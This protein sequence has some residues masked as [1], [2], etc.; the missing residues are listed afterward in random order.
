MDNKKFHSLILVRPQMG[1]N[2]GACARAMKNFNFFNELR[3]VSPRDGWPNEKALRN[4]AGGSDIIESAKIFDNLNDAISDLEYLY[5]STARKRDMNINSVEVRNLKEDYN[6]N[7]KS[8]VMFGPE[9]SGLSNDEIHLA[10]KIIYID[11]NQDFPSINLSQAVMLVCYEL[12]KES[13]SIDF[14]NIQDLASKS[15]IVMLLDHLFIALEKNDF[16][17]EENKKPIMKRNIA[18]IF[19]RIDKFSIS[20]VQTFRGIIASSFNEKK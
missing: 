12:F 15:E 3:I 13:D 5:A 6:L 9:N 11:A 16:F 19:N 18:N 4:S 20:E 7:L 17:Q 14:D 8:G 1:E 2:I 10:N